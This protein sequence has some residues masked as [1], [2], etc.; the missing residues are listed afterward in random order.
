MTNS[1]N[2]TLKAA[3]LADPTL[4]TAVELADDEAIADAMNSTASPDYW[5]WRTH[6]TRQDAEFSTS[7]DNTTWSFTAFIARSQGERDCW[8]EMLADG[9][10][11]PSL[12]NV[13]QGVADIF[14]GSANSAPQQRTHLL[15]VS[16]R[17]AS[18]VEKLFATGGDGSTNNV[19]TMAV[20]GPIS[21]SEVSIA[22]R[23]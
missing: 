1:Q 7:V 14:S 6:L 13:R 18:R 8:R 20:E 23:D 2:Q 19:S 3:I 16:R 9:W 21:Y 5:V 10:V 17:K 15:A 22:L 4:V 11:N 12:V